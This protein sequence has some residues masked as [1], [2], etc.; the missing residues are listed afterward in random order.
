MQIKY[1]CIKLVLSNLFQLFRPKI[2][3]L[4]NTQLSNQKQKNVG[5]EFSFE[6]LMGGGT[7]KRYLS[8]NFWQCL[9]LLGKKKNRFVCLKTSC[10]VTNL[11]FTP[12]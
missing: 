5:L 3:Y 11:A 6:D 1:T 9:L 10:S 4:Q 12:L 7:I 8:R 2:I